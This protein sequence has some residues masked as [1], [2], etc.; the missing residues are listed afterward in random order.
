MEEHT[1]IAH[2]LDDKEY[3]CWKSCV[4]GWQKELKLYQPKNRR[5]LLARFL[6]IGTTQA[7]GGGGGG[8]VVPRSQCAYTSSMLTLFSAATWQVALFA[9]LIVVISN[10]GKVQTQVPYDNWLLVSY[11]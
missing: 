1:K 10:V 2:D 11:V 8:G 6:Y 5:M 9:V 3:K 4:F 7:K